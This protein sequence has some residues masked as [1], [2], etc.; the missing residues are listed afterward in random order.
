MAQTL[1]A[2]LQVR[3]RVAVIDVRLPEPHLRQMLLRLIVESVRAVSVLRCQIRQ[4]RALVP[5]R[6]IQ[7]PRRRR[8]VVHPRARQCAAQVRT[9]VRKRRAALPCQ[10]IQRSAVVAQHI[11]ILPIRGLPI[12]LQSLLLLL[13]RALPSLPILDQPHY[14]GDPA[15]YR[16]D[17]V[18]KSHRVALPFV[19]RPASRLHGIA[20][21]NSP[22]LS[23]PTNSALRPNRQAGRWRSLPRPA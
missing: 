21:K 4:V 2:A 15:H 17:I 16:S 22:R 18:E 13:Q 9:Q 1:P 5:L 20:R 23:P 6:L 19:V 14:R 7:R 3:V 10:P 12:R 8:R 11:L